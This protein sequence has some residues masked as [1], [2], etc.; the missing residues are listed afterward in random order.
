[1]QIEIIKLQIGTHAQL[2]FSMFETDASPASVPCVDDGWLLH[3]SG[4]LTILFSFAK[5]HRT[6][7]LRML[8]AFQ[9]SLIYCQLPFCQ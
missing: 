9:V 3:N 6:Y 2:N 1:M 5:A 7:C 8:L 4:K